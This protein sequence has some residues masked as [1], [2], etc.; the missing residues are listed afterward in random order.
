[1]SGLRPVLE[2]LK[3]NERFKRLLP[4]RPVTAGM[5]SGYVVLKPGESVGE[6]KT[7]SR[8]EGIII[9]EGSAEIIVEGERM[10]TARKENLIYIPPET[11]HDIKNISDEP[12]R[13]VYVVVPTEKG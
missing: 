11:S 10:F 5:K 8:E 3:G 6:H 13:Y 7:E 12:L 2:E 1:M 9:L 4:G